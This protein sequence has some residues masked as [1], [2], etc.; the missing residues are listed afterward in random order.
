M[1][2]GFSVMCAWAWRLAPTTDAGIRLLLIKYSLHSALGSAAMRVASSESSVVTEFSPVTNAA[3][4]GALPDDGREAHQSVERFALWVK[5]KSFCC[6]AAE[7][8]VFTGAGAAVGTDAAAAA[9]EAPEPEALAREAVWRRL[10]ASRD[11]ERL[12]SLRARAA[13]E[14]AGTGVAIS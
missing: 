2:I 13:R 14:E 3:T 8:V 4:M 12:R 9:E 10:A 1:S 6:G 5:S 7:I 11:A